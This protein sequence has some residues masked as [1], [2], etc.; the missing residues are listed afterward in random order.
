M[1]LAWDLTVE[2]ML[3]TKNWK[4]VVKVIRLENSLE[5]LVKFDT[6]VMLVYLQKDLTDSYISYFI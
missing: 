1:K 4:L 5:R 3:S 2:Y 6:F